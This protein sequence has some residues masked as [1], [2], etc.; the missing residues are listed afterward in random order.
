MSS[1][2][3]VLWCT[4]RPKEE[5][6]ISVWRYKTHTSGDAQAPKNCKG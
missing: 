3:K 1:K 6:A 4:H 2:A 5:T